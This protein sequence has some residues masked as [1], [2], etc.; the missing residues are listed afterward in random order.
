M[1]Y[2]HTKFKQNRWSHLWENWNFKIVFLCELPL[3]LGVA[4]KRKEEA[5]DIY[6]GTPDIEFE[7]DE[8]VGLGTILADGQKIKNYF[9]SFRDFFGKSR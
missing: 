2:K 9:S 4:R 3:I 6:K 8:S 7:Q 1:Y 5:G